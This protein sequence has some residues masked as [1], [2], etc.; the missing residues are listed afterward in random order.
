M[1]DCHSWGI[2]HIVCLRQGL[3]LRRWSSSSRLG[4]MA[5]EL[6]NLHSSTPLL[7]QDSKHTRHGSWHFTRALR[8]KLRSFT[9]KA[10][11][12]PAES[13][14]QLVGESFK[15]LPP[16]PPLTPPPLFSAT[17]E[18]L[19]VFVESILLLVEES[20]LCLSQ[21]QQVSPDSQAV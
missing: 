3:S 6:R 17:I 18:V 15:H 5:T 16:P 10:S 14:P 2:V 13:P 9:C 19:G 20:R 4:L 11:F 21:E 1:S 12:L 7:C 8:I